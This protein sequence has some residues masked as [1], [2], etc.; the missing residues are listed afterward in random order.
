MKPVPDAAKAE[1]GAVLVE[2]AIVLPLLVLLFL[3]VIDLGLVI[4]ESQVLQNAVREGARF[5]AL[6]TSWVD[7]RNPMASEATV[8]R[9]V[10]DY[11]LEEGIVVDP[12]AVGLNQRYLINVGGGRTALASEV[13]VSYERPFL[14]PGAPLL[15]FARVRLASRAVFR[16]LY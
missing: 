10:T 6:P 15:P 8:R 5:S 9:R 12:A 7:P 16:N 14:I 3:T 13:T 4:R 1:Q 11:C 2:F